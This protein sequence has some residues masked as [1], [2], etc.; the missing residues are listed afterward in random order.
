MGVWRANMHHGN[1]KADW[2]GCLS[3]LG[4]YGL[5]GAMSGGGCGCS[6]FFMWFIILCPIFF[7]YNLIAG[8]KME[9]LFYG[10]FTAI[11][12]A[13]ILYMVLTESHHKRILKKIE[14]KM[15]TEWKHSHIK[16]VKAEYAG[17]KYRVVASV[18]PDT[19]FFKTATYEYYVEGSTLSEL[20]A[21]MEEFLS[22]HP[23][24]S[25]GTTIN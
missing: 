8:N 21:N 9:T 14:Q 18:H 3:A 19:Q 24:T 1:G 2:A 15:H 7:I 11:I 16:L 13:V 10:F 22:G 17:G 12:L 5:G 20:T 25:A 6:S 23:D 4:F